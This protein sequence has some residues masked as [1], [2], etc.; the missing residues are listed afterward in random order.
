MKEAPYAIIVDG[1]RVGGAARARAD[2]DRHKVTLEEVDLFAKLF[3]GAHVVPE[4]PAWEPQYRHVTVQAPDGPPCIEAERA[5]VF[6]FSSGTGD[7]V[8]NAQTLVTR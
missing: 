5:S 7:V 4:G 3:F 2:V 1:T 8:L 6:S